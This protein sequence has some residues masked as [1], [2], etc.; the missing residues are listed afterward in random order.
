VTALTE[1]DARAKLDAYVAKNGHHREPAEGSGQRRLDVMLAAKAIATHTAAEWRAKCQ[2]I[3]Y[4]CAYCN[5]HN[6][7]MHKD[8]IIPITRGG[9]DSI[10]NVTLAC[11][12]C[13]SLKSNMTAE[14][15]L[16]YNNM[17][18]RVLTPIDSTPALRAD[19]LG[20]IGVHVGYCASGRDM[21]DLADDL[22]AAGWST[23]T[24]ASA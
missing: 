14:E 19:L 12:R 22:I 11:Y 17:V 23:V 5:G 1:E 6:Q 18:G 21:E 13:N 2:A 10:D 8:H 24:S 15:F 20:T 9:S 3:G 4:R 16:H 7:S